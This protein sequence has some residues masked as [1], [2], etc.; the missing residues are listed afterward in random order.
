LQKEID[1]IADRLRFSG[2]YRD[3]RVVEISVRHLHGLESGSITTTS[4]R[5]LTM[6]IACVVCGKEVNLDHA[7]FQN[8]QGPVKCFS[9]G[10]MMEVKTARGTLD[11]VALQGGG[12]VHTGKTG[13]ISASAA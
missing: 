11:N 7:I 9:C 6:R 10:T 8:Y 2:A 3:R 1:R 4:T 12:G 5:E 13:S